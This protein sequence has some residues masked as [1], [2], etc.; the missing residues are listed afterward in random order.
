MQ[1]MSMQVIPDGLLHGLRDLRNFINQ[2]VNSPVGPKSAGQVLIVVKADMQVR[3]IQ[4]HGQQKMTPNHDCHRNDVY[5]AQDP[6]PLWDE[7]QG[8]DDHSG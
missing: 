1:E 5:E 3:T 8:H 4:N 6:V 7:I 2:A